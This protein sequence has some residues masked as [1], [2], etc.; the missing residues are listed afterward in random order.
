MKANCKK[1]KWTLIIGCIVTALPMLVGLIL[2][3]RLPDEIATHFGSGNVANGWSSKP[4]TVFGIPGIMVALEL[5][6]YFVT[7]NDPKKRNIDDKIMRFCLWIIPVTSLLVCLSCYGIALGIP[8]DIGFLVNI[9]IGIMLIF[10]GNYLHRI[11]QNYTVGIKLPW[12]L[13]SEENW[14]RTHRMASWLFVICGLL[15]I[16]NAFF[17]FEAMYFAVLLFAFIP[18]VYSYILY[19]KG[20]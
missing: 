5:V 8:V 11:K 15:F 4:F 17:Q 10:L 6:L 18:G 16:V 19:K 7:T 3:N 20:I 12:T 1:Y 2:W 14:N 13:N 9:L